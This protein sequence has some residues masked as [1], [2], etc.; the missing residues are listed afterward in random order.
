MRL[1]KRCEYGIKAAVGLCRGRNGQFVR[2]RQLASAEDLPAKFL[3][4]VLLSMKTAQI[5]ESRVGASGGYRLARHPSEIRVMDL[6]VAL[7][8]RAAGNNNSDSRARTPVE[9]PGQA[10]LDHVVHRLGEALKSAVGNLT[11]ADLSN[12]ADRRER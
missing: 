1:S 7:D 11:L 10:A 12:S 3:E 5:L 8:D 9:R 2:S 4:S 6:I